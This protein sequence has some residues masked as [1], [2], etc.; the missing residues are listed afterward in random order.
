[1]VKLIA[2]TDIR[3]YDDNGKPEPLA[4]SEYEHCQ[5]CGKAIAVVYEVNN[6]G[7]VEFIGSECYIKL[8]GVKATKAQI[9]VAMRVSEAREIVKVLHADDA[10]T[11]CKT[12]TFQD[13]MNYWK[14]FDNYSQAARNIANKLY[15]E[16]TK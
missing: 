3:S 1:M 10:N 9:A 16:E 2:V 14:K 8:T 6:N 12:W 15:Y 7:I 11:L 5:H 13:R 4:K